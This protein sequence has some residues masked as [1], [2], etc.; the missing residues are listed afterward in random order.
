MRQLRA[1]RLPDSQGEVQ[2]SP[3]TKVPRPIVVVRDLSKS[4]CMLLSGTEEG[5]LLCYS[6]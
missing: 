5:S 2:D 4:A 3:E 1:S 6:D